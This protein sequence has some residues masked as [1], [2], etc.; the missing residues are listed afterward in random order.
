MEG[1]TGF[2]K[3]QRVQRGTGSGASSLKYAMTAGRE[4]R[5]AQQ[6]EYEVYVKDAVEKEKLRIEK[7]ADS[8]FRKVKQEY[9]SDYETN[10]RAGTSNWTKTQNALVTKDIIQR[11]KQKN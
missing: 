11:Q 3:R 6:A 10:L 7:S 5:Q 8:T 2:N 9:L 4:Q 1:F